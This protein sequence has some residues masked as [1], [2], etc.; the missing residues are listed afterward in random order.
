MHLSNVRRVVVKMSLVM[1]PD[2]GEQR[3]P[4]VPSFSVSDS[5]NELFFLE[6]G[7]HDSTII[8]PHILRYHSSNPLL[9]DNSLLRIPILNDGMLVGTRRISGGCTRSRS[10]PFP[11][12]SWPR[13]SR[14]ETTAR[15]PKSD[16]T[17]SHTTNRRN[18]REK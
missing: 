13:R 7:Q 1:V 14:T 5:D 2:D 18:T 6:M 3:P 8:F 4:L 10:G 15:A 9:S 12:W 11:W 17:S 16:R